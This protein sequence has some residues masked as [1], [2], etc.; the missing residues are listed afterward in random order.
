MKCIEVKI[1]HK[2]YDEYLNHMKNSKT[3]HHINPSISYMKDLFDLREKV[4]THFIL[5]RVVEYKI[6]RSE[7]Q[8]LDLH[9][10]T[11]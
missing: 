9:R 8:R 3:A 7:I 4:T 1:S 10:H 6:V 11:S 2:K 5:L